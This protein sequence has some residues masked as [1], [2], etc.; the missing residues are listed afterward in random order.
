MDKGQVQSLQQTYEDLSHV[1]AI[2]S[3]D[4][5]IMLDL[6]SDHYLSLND[7]GKR[8]W[9]LL[10]DGKTGQQIVEQL[11]QEYEV[12]TRTLE[13]DVVNLL[14]QLLEMGLVAPTTDPA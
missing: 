10:T 9:E 8:I 5:I 12:D 14:Q 6:D 13:Q 4:K 2:A 7:T 11:T 1:Y 3:G